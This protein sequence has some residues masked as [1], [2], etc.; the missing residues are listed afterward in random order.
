MAGRTEFRAGDSD[1]ARCVDCSNV[2]FVM[3]RS[4][5]LL[6][7]L[8]AL[9]AA[10]SAVAPRPRLSSRALPGLISPGLRLASRVSLSFRARAAYKL[11]LALVRR[12]PRTALLQAE[13][14]IACASRLVACQELRFEQRG[15]PFL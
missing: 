7:A 14:R 11:R 4:R 8:R 5:R 1:F 9:R 12:M 6:R 13:S 3:A 15:A 2:R 10:L